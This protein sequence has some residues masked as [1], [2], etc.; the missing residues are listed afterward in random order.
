MLP[1]LDGEDS[2]FEMPSGWDVIAGNM[3]VPHMGCNNP[4][5]VNNLSK[6]IVTQTRDTWGLTCVLAYS[7]PPSLPLPRIKSPDDP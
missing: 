6:S 3:L 2:D 7:H 5:Q 4:L 1:D